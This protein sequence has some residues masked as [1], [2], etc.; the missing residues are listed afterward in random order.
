MLGLNSSA[1]STKA[2]PVKVSKK[3]EE[4]AAAETPVEV[5]APVPAITPEPL[6]PAIEKPA[7][8]AKPAGKPAA[9]KALPGS[10]P[11]TAKVVWTGAEIPAKAGT[12]RAARYDLIA[13]NNSKTV[14]EVV[15][16]VAARYLVR[17]VTKK[18]ATIEQ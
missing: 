3:A 1:K 18:F 6:P 11:A 12:K 14:E 2:P 15:K 4:K 17:A 10:L 8:K 5:L 7:E 13:K 16:L 9:K